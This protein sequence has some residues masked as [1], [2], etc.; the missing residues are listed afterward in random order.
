M[1][2]F[3]INGQDGISLPE[4]IDWDIKLCDSEI[5]EEVGINNILGKF[6]QDSSKE[7]NVT[8]LLNCKGYFFYLQVMKK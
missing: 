1:D 7:Y 4:M 3:L 5:N 2:L 8:E 6:C